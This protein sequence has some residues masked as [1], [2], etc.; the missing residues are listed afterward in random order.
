M[1]H[2]LS[3]HEVVFVLFVLMKYMS[4]SLCQ[5]FGETMAVNYSKGLVFKDFS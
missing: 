4:T 2:F 3:L 1:L 5:L